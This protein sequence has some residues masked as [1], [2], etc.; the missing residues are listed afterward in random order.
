MRQNDPT[1]QWLLEGDAAIRWQV[2]RDLVKASERTVEREQQKVAKTGWGARLLQLQEADGQWGGGIYTPKWTSTTYTMVLLR[3]LGLPPKHPQA[4]KAC[5]LLFD[6]GFYRDGG[7]N[8]WE[9]YDYSETCVTGMLLAVAAYFQFADDR[10]HAFAKYL[11]KQQMGD[12]GW[13]CRFQR[14]A[15]HGSFH[16]TI[17][18]L[19][20]LLEYERLNPRH[21]AKIRRAQARGREF[22][23]VHR[24]FRSHRTGN[25]VNS[26]MT[27]FSFPPRWHYDILRGLDYFREA[28]ARQDPRL[29]EAIDIVRQRRKDDGR[30]I[31]QNRYPGRVFFEM[32][33]LG[34]PSRW[35]T[36][37]ALRVLKWWEGK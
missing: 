2:L 10:V 8:C 34:Q 30:W 11:L 32:E 17:L 6:R 4:L 27:G 16:T 36:L 15:T 26:A 20:G 23:L 28:G 9:S 18:V 24:L 25:V 33:K 29:G 3:Q 19:E 7:F 13:N 31:L 22:L 35:N 1:V 14:G 12:G 37:R 5:V 21:A